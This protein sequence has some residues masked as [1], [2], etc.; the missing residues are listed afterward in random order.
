MIISNLA[1]FFNLK[2]NI[3]VNTKLRIQIK[4]Y[5]HRK[6]IFYELLSGLVIK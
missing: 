3:K 1:N 2:S 6:N 5:F 4:Y